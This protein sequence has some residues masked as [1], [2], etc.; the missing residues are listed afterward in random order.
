MIDESRNPQP[1]CVAVLA[2][3]DSHEREVSLA[4]GAEALRALEA[5]GHQVE[6]YDPAQTPLDEVAGCRFDV[7]FIALHGGPGEDGRIQRQLEQLGVVYTGSPPGASRRNEYSG[8]SPRRQ[9][10]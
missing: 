7:C 9:R 2:G 3:G 8:K 1:L 6:L 10:T 5:A 4:S